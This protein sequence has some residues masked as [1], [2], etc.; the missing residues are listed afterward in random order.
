M[1]W[2]CSSVRRRCL[3]NF[4]KVDVCSNSNNTNANFRVTFWHIK[5]NFSACLPSFSLATCSHWFWLATVPPVGY[6]VT[7]VMTVSQMSSCQWQSNPSAR[8]PVWKWLT[9]H[10]YVWWMEPVSVLPTFFYLLRQANPFGLSYNQLD[11][12]WSS[13]RAQT[14]HLFMLNV[15]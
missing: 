6:R 1:G 10:L 3:R 2:F 11:P 15:R 4:C 13:T 7:L 12:L 5:V 8:S 14:P 9:C